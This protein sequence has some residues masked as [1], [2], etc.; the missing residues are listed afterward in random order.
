[1][2]RKTQNSC[3]RLYDASFWVEPQEVVEPD[4]SVSFKRIKCSDISAQQLDS[5]VITAHSLLESGNII[6]PNGSVD[7]IISPTIEDA[8]SLVSNSISDEV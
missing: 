8:V 1:M 3:G 7:G 4:N 5:S 6:E 2:F